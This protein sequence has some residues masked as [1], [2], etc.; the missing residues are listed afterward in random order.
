MNMMTDNSAFWRSLMGVA[1]S[2]PDPS[3][4]ILP[5]Y[6]YGHPMLER[7]CREVE[8]SGTVAMALYRMYCT[9]V[10]ANGAGLAGPQVGLPQRLV[11]IRTEHEKFRDD[12]QAVGQNPLLMIN[13]VIADASKEM[14]TFEGEAC[15]SMPGF[16]ATTRRHRRVKVRYMDFLGRPQSFW[17]E[18]QRL[19]GCVQHEEQHL[20]GEM[21]WSKIPNQ[22]SLLRQ[23][24]D[25]A[26]ICRSHLWPQPYPMVWVEDKSGESLA[27]E[28][29]R[30]FEQN[31]PFSHLLMHNEV[32]AEAGLHAKIE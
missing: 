2:V 19:A 23:R 13:P 6:G 7:I 18:S 12:W 21:F 24:L 4:D 14:M 5:I 10:K 16:R 3:S 22:Q 25:W 29:K 17:T 32:P 15:L 20:N 26:D 27:Q 1:D 8:P 31:G 9:L 11:V 30:A 28:L